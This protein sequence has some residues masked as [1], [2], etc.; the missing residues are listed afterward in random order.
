MRRLLHVMRKEFLELRQDPRI[1]R[2]NSSIASPT[3]A[4]DDNSDTT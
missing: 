1:G 2:P 4:I 3:I